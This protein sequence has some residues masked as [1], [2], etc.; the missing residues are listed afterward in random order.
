MRT[1]SLVQRDLEQQNAGDVEANPVSHNAAIGCGFESRSK[2]CSSHA[3]LY[4]EQFTE[5]LPN[6]ILKSCKWHFHSKRIRLL[7]GEI[8]E[9]LLD[10]VF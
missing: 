9:E 7:V 4:I 1:K 3:E 8:L 5:P 6:G 2:D 10:A